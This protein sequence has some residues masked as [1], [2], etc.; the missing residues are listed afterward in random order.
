MDSKQVV[1]AYDFSPEADLGLEHAFELACREPDHVLHVIAAIPGADDDHAEEVRRC[2][3]EGLAWAFDDRAPAGGVQFYVHA[4]IGLPAVEILDLAEEI[5][6]DL[7]I[8]GAASAGATTQAVVGAA[9]CPVVV[10]RPK[11]YPHVTSV[12]VV[13]LVPSR[14]EHWPL[15]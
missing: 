4:R 10:V 3:L 6:A 11:A 9:R 13:R 5:G 1:V 7:L 14:P 8:L 2:L 12:P 15:H